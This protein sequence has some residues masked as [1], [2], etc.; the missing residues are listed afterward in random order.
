MIVYRASF[1]GTRRRRGSGLDSHEIGSRRVRPDPAHVA[2]RQLRTR[3]RYVPDVEVEGVR[4]G[5]V[6]EDDRDGLDVLPVREVE[7]GEGVPKRIRPRTLE[8]GLLDELV[9]LVDEGAV[10]LDRIELRHDGQSV[11]RLDAHLPK[12]P[13]LQV[14]P[15]ADGVGGVAVERD[16]PARG[17]RLGV[18]LDLVAVASHGTGDALRGRPAEGET[19]RSNAEYLLRPHAAREEEQRLDLEGA[20]G[21]RL[22]LGDEAT[23]LLLGE[24]VDERA[25]LLEISR[26][27][28]RL[29]HVAV[30]DA[31]VDRVV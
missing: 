11:D 29:R 30:D 25:A 7:G 5:R 20:Q 21:E 27:E 15:L 14:E 13:P 12:P 26:E 1:H 22:D 16:G 10:R 9:P 3:R 28:A 6:P 24:G 31:P 17:T 23:G 4:R 19:A 2:V 8:P 18:L